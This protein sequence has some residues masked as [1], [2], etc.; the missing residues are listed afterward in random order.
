MINEETCTYIIKSECHE[1]GFAIKGDT[2]MASGDVDISILEWRNNLITPADDRDALISGAFYAGELPPALGTAWIEKD[3]S[4]SL[5]AELGIF[6]NSTV[7]EEYSGHWI[8]VQM[9]DM[10]ARYETFFTARD[11]YDLAKNEYNGA[12][13]LAG[14]QS[15][16]QILD[17]VN[18]V[19]PAS[20]SPF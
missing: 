9:K 10:Q 20:S 18:M 11:T 17:I 6:K 14:M 19:L 1:P 7:D 4:S 8:G 12:L 5:P 16:N 15:M 13:R 2:T 3:D